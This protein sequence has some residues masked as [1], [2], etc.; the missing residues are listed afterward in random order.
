MHQGLQHSNQLDGPSLDHLQYF[1]VSF[2]VGVQNWTRYSKCDLT[3]A[4]WNSDNL[5]SVGFTLADA[6][7]APGWFH[8]CKDA[9]LIQSVPGLHCCLGLFH[10]RHRMLQLSLLNIIQFMLAQSSSLLRS[11]HGV[12]YT[13]YLVVSYSILSHRVWSRTVCISE[14]MDPC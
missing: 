14:G 11:L 8:C 6:V 12:P 5:A 10:P 2:E 3:N 7:K 9:H 1:N 13:I 4:K